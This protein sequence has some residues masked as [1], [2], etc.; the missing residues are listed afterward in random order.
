MN[1]L[2]KSSKFQINEII[3]IKKSL[4]YKNIEMFNKFSILHIIKLN[5]RFYIYFEK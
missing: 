3:A 1:S 5:K 2:I 4:L